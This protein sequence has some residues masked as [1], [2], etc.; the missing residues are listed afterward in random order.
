MVAQLEI[1]VAVRDYEG[2]YEVSNLGRVKSLPKKGSGGHNGKI[3]K[4]TPDGV[5]YLMVALCG[6]GKPKTFRVHKLVYESFN[7]KTDLHIDHIAEGNKQDNRLCNLQAITCRENITKYHLTKNTSSK[8][9]GVTWHKT[10]GKWVSNININGK[11]NR[12]GSFIN[13]EEA[14]EAYQ[15]ALKSL[16]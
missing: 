10:D 2:L 16:K 9:T 11:L 6:K 3:L 12:L 8:Y 4:Q 1:W 7:G 13:E 14:S 5:G 15:N